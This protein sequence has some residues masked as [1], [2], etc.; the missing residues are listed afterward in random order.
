MIGM[1]ERSLWH[2]V[3]LSADVVGAPV[4]VQLLDEALVLWRDASGLMHAW[5]DRCPHRGAKLSLGR[6]QGDKLECGYHGWMFDVSARCVRVPALPSF[7]PPASHCATKYFACEQ[8]GM[9]WVSLS[10]PSQPLPLFDVASELRIV[11]CGPYDVATSAPRVVENFLDM[12]HFGFV[13]EGY[14]GARDAAGVADYEVTRTATGI[15]A[16]GCRAWQ[17]HSHAHAQQGADVSYTYKVISPF[18]AM[19]TK[20]SDQSAT[21]VQGQSA[22]GH[23]SIAL[24]VCPVSHEQS[25]VWFSLAARVEIAGGT[26]DADGVQQV[27]DMKN[28]QDAQNVQTLRDFQDTIFLQDKPILESQRPKRLPLDLRAELHTT[29]DKAS[30]AY[31]RFLQETHI[32]F[33]VC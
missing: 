3:A 15:E 13:H 28:A 14:L 11:Q 25:R 7:T 24:W 20:I 12:A 29:A 17:P 6:V 10:E 2:P 23:E 27:R 9:V 21:V 30:S 8:Y 1:V 33:G 16:T 26:S 19:L 18:C 5:Q 4:S 32:T 22:Q 31:R